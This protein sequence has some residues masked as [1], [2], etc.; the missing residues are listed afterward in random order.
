MELMKSKTQYLTF[1]DSSKINEHEKVLILKNKIFKEKNYSENIKCEMQ[2]MEFSGFRINKKQIPLYETKECNTGIYVKEGSTDIY[3]KEGTQLFEHTNISFFLSL[4]LNNIKSRIYFVINDKIDVFHEILILNNVL[5]HNKLYKG[6]CFSV[7]FTEDSLCIK[8]QT[9]AFIKE[10]VQ[11][12]FFQSV[13][14]AL[15]QDP[16]EDPSFQKL[17]QKRNSRIPSSISKLRSHPSFIT[18]TLLSNTEYIYPMRPILGLISGEKV[19]PSVNV[20]KLRTIK[21]WDRIG[22]TVVDSKPFRIITKGNERV[23]LYAEYQTKETVITQITAKIMPA[24]H[25]NQTPVNCIRI[26]HDPGIC[27]ELNLRYA[28]CLVG[29]RGREMV[30]NGFYIEKKNCFVVNHFI[31][32]REYYNKVKEEIQKHEEFQGEL[33]IFIRKAKRYLDIKRRLNIE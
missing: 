28:N 31:R 30:L 27:I 13:L 26:N 2:P 6:N 32:Q 20:R 10:P 18:E 33:K 16:K 1:K 15:D 29:F 24:F 22:R 19:F 3:V 4:N 12:N 14:L 7:S 11:R 17:D 23:L 8:N 9:T 5:E 21:G 25:P